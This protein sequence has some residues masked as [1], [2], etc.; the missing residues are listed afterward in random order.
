MAKDTIQIK[1]DKVQSSVTEFRSVRSDNAFD[2]MAI[3]CCES[4]SPKKSRSFI[5]EA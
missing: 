4:D 5:T 2:I 1:I 3:Y